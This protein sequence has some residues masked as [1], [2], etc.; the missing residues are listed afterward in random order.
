MRRRTRRLPHRVRGLRGFT[1]L[2][3]MNA[4]AL[5]CIVAALGMYIAARYVRHS[6]TAE[7]VNS[8][9]ALATGAANFYENESTRTE[10]VGTKPDQAR[11]MRRFPPISRTSVPPSPDD[12]KGK[13]YQSSPAEWKRA[14]W[15]NLGF[16]MHQPQYYLYS[17]E[18]QG[19]G[20]EATA[21]AT[22]HG[23][24]NGDGN[25]STF[26][27]TVG[28]DE[29]FKAVVSPNLVRENPEE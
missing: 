12:V 27:L 3:L 1:V 22:A 25:L 17:F 28:V 10:P 11:Q 20:R 18:S 24:L 19:A 16:S 26:R 21:T 13:R 15:D 2:E 14:P 7:A 4:L 29:K 6:R 5:T 23:D 9:Q 8:V